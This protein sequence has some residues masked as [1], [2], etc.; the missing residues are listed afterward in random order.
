MYHFGHAELPAEQV[1]SI[2]EA[3]KAPVAPEPI[4]A[5]DPHPFEGLHAEQAKLLRNEVEIESR[6]D[7]LRVDLKSTFRPLLNYI[8]NLAGKKTGTLREWKDIGEQI[9]EVEL[10]PRAKVRLR[11]RHKLF[12]ERVIPRPVNLAYAFIPLIVFY[13]VKS[14]IN[15]KMHEKRIEDLLEKKRLKRREEQQA[16]KKAKQASKTRRP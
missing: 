9:N 3:K 12:E 2:V 14:Y 15:S 5:P 4:V 8:V 16:R 7:Q 11:H 13:F 10:T 6:L 1:K